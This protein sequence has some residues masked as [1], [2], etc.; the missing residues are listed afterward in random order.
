M[1]PFWL[2]QA[3][4]YVIGAVFISSS[5]QSET[6]AVPAVLG[7]AVMIN[8]ALTVGPA[9]AFRFYGRKTHRVIDI[10]IVVAVMVAAVQP[11]IALGDNARVLMGMLGFVLAF[12]WWNT[13][14]AD[15]D[16]RRQRRLAKKS[17]RQRP[18][19]P[20]SEEIGQKAGRIV[21]DGINF[22][23]RAKNNLTSDKDS[24]DD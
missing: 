20:T 8:A 22:A 19:R 24:S 13:D 17:A 9:G 12:V 16:E 7:V 4:E 3:V 1:R 11:M 18:A 14:F 15:K 23:K 5:I 10:G 6:P 21:G 2:H